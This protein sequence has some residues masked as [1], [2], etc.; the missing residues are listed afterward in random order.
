MQTYVR[1][2]SGLSRAAGLVSVALLAAAL[3]I[4]CQMVAMRYLLRA[5]TVWQ[6]EFVVYSVV[7]ATFLGSA[8]VLMEKGHV[9]V[10]LLPGALRPR[11]RVFLE[12]LSGLFSLIFCALLAW[13]GWIHFEEAWSKGWTTA[14]VW[15]LPLWIPLLP[16]PLGIGLLCLQY[17]AEL[18]KLRDELR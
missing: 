15:A 6:T 9:N 14:T 13:S 17:V 4:V 18:I 2:V 7:A 8:W 3:L 10:D 11:S 1:I 12:A 16:L 5:S